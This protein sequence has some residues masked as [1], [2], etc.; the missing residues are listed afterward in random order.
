GTLAAGTANFLARSLQ[1][2]ERT[3]ADVMTPRIQAEMIDIDAPLTDVIDAARRTGFSRFP[4]TGDSA[5]DVRGVV[6][7]KRAIAVPT[8]KREG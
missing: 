1:F 3:A 4:V 5:D 7:V 6:H 8:D 2:S